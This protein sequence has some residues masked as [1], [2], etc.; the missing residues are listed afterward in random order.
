MQEYWSGYPSP[1]SGKSPDVG[2]EPTLFT[3]P[4]L[5]SRLFTIS[6]TWEEIIVKTVKSQFSSAAQSCPT[7]CNPVDCSTPAFSVHHQLQE[8]TQTHVH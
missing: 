5:A 8:L 6:A 4:A 3:S 2:I 1:S 7:L